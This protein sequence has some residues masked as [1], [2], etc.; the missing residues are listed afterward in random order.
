MILA[1]GTSGAR[2][3]DDRSY[4]P[5]AFGETSLIERFRMPPL[6]DA[7]AA[8]WASR[9]GPRSETL[10]STTGPRGFPVATV[11]QAPGKPGKRCVILDTLSI[12]IRDTF[13]V[14]NLMNLSPT[15]ST[16]KESNDDPA[17]WRHLSASQSFWDWR[18]WC[19][20]KRNK[21]QP[22]APAS[23]ER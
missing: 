18:E 19:K 13:H 12:M 17:L 21:Q 2:G 7:E 4:P 6:Q 8:V 16:I 15:G 11:D 22:P 9:I 3:S 23:T 1:S 20:L 10:Q 5:T 14:G